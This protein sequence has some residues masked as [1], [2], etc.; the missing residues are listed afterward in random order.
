M[1]VKLKGLNRKKVRLANGETI[2]YYYAWKGGPRVHG[3]PGT[4]EFFSSYSE[5]I[6]NRAP[7]GAKILA[8][9]F[10]DYSESPKFLSK[11]DRTRRDYL[12]HIEKIEHAFGD[13]PVEG[14][15]DRRARDEFLT[16]GD[17]LALASKRQG[18]YTMTV[19]ALMLAWAKK[20]G[21]IAHNPLEKLERYYSGT[22]AEI[23]WTD[24]DEAALA[25]VAS[26]PLRLALMLA[27]WTG[28]R[29]GDILKMAWSAYDGRLIKVRANKTNS[30]LPIPAGKPLREL[31]DATR[32]QSPLIVTNTRGRPYSENGFRAS[33]AKACDK[34]G[35][36]GITFHDLRGTAVTR[37]AIAG[38][39]EPEIAAVT[40]HSIGDVRSILEKHYLKRD[41][42][43]AANA[44][45]K[46]ERRTEIPE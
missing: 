26:Q 40:G 28:Q 3:N 4:H 30:Y 10:R 27:L 39:S 17:K 31:L 16:W 7:Q 18:D 42:A 33:W 34:A 46:L 14:L 11:A 36:S 38:A 21:K 35:L 37:L 29:Q 8:K 12:R 6:K 2:I 20:R 44:I 19:F 43:L 25:R 5:A 1:R 23:I 22:R 32:R 41:P 15:I 24:D 9:I 45:A 13:F